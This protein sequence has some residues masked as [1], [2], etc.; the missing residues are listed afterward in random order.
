MKF[1]ST[2]HDLADVRIGVLFF[3]DSVIFGKEVKK[4]PVQLTFGSAY[5]SHC[6]ST[7]RFSQPFQTARARIT[8]VENIVLVE[9]SKL[10]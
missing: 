1:G 2:V 3:N 6:D 5:Q 9:R 10:D 7:A 8:L 4:G